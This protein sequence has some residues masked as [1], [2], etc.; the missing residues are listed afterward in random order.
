MPVAFYQISQ[1]RYTNSPF[2]SECTTLPP[3]IVILSK[4]WQPGEFRET[5]AVEELL[6]TIEFLLEKK[7]DMSVR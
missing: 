4:I 6:R 7:Y 1:I 5:R 3:T 2:R